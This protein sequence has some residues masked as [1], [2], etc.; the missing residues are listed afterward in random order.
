[1]AL[2][3]EIGRAIRRRRERLGMSQAELGHAIKRSTQAVGKIERGK[4]GPTYETLQLIATALGSPV[5]DF[6]PA[7]DQVED[8][9]TGRIVARL[10]AL[11]LLERAWIEDIL[12]AIL[13]GARSG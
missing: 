10:N 12:S 11:S 9:V 5:R 6:F 1:M 13:R 3:E 2:Q 4:T 7:E 8:D